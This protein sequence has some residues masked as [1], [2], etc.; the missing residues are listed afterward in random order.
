MVPRCLLLLT[1][2]SIPARAADAPPLPGTK[3]LTEHVDF[4][5]RMREGI[6]KYLLRE[7]VSSVETRKTLWKR[8]F[9]S[10][11]AYE[12]S[13]EPNRERFRKIIG[14]VDSR[15]PVV[16]ERC[17]DEDNPALVAETGTYRVYQVRWPVLEGVSGEGLLLE[18]K[19]APL[20]YVVALPDADQ[21][22]EQIVGLAVERPV[23]VCV[24]LRKRAGPVRDVQLPLRLARQP[25]RVAA[26]RQVGLPCL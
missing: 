1:L 15:A 11:A 21:T 18:P 14:V 5:V 26:V 17:G 8:D 13:V 10:R 4:S 20:A 12:K 2:V 16:M 25:G 23:G 7:I 6:E 9:S 24:E 3:P 22:P 19:R